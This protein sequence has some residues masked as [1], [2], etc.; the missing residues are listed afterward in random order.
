MLNLYQLTYS[1]AQEIKNNVNNW[2][3]NN[4]A[5]NTKKTQGGYGGYS[6]ANW[7]VLSFFPKGA[8]HVALQTILGRSLQILGAP[9]A[10]L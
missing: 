4:I 6:F 9:K 2:K 8:I 7:Y 10:N 1:K 3:S 5:R